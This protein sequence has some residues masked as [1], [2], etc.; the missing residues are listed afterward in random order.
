MAALT[1]VAL[2]RRRRTARRHH[3]GL[4]GGQNL[5]DALALLYD[6]WSRSTNLRTPT[7]FDDVAVAYAIDPGLCP[8]TPLRI[9]VDAKGFTRE[10][11]GKPNAQVCLHSDTDKFLE[12]YMPRLLEQKLS[13]SCAKPR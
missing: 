4:G 12:F 6:Q 2:P 1:S 7:L 11:S 10:V 5:T 9:E 3:A 13:G 8:T